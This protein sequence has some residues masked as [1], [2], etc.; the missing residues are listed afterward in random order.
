MQ[1][2]QLDLLQVQKHIQE[3]L[4]ILRDTC[5][6]CEEEFIKLYNETELL[7][8]SVGTVILAPRQTARQMNRANLPNNS[9]EEF[10]RR[11]V[12]IP[13]LDS[14]ISS[15]DVRF[16]DQNKPAYSLM[17][18][19]P[20][21][22]LKLTKELFM[23]QARQVNEFYDIDNFLEQSSTWYDLWYNRQHQQSESYTDVLKMDLTDVLDHHTQLF[24]GIQ[25]ALQIALALPATTCTIERSFSTLRRVKTWL[26]STMTTERLSGLCMISVHRQL[27]MKN[28]IQ[29]I[30]KIVSRFAE[31]PRRLQLLFKD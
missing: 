9:T 28:K 27:I 18:I 13:Y 5:A 1:A 10:Y 19:H 24:P 31:N 7:A 15:L 14:I 11:S 30:D 6:R 4:I 23:V 26:R 16:A 21:Q 20:I 22:M 2:V 8:D 29:F 17:T 12:Y 3:M 25:Q